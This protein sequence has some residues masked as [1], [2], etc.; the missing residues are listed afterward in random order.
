MKKIIVRLL[1]ALVVLAVLAAVAVHLFLDSAVKRTVESVGSDLMKVEVKLDLVNLSLLSGSG[2]I[3]GL[4]VGNPAGYK[5]PSAISVGTASVAI[6]AASLL[7]D[8][9]VVQSINVQAPE[10][11]FE[12]D[13]LQNNL[14][15]LLANLRESSGSGKEPAQTKEGKTSKKLEVDNFVLRGGKVRVSVSTLGGKAATVA[16]P[17]IHLKDLGR[18]AEGITPAQLTSKVLEEVVAAATRVAAGAVADLTKGG[19]FLSNE[20]GKAAT[21]VVDKAT[22]GIGDLFKTK[23]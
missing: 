17:E 12:T 13:L 1:I 4:V 23:K 16:L 2:K 19:V 6:Q 9:I 11:T 14:S 20:T 15:K 7:S 22:R 8:K 3:K 10:V 18:D 21:N 5:T